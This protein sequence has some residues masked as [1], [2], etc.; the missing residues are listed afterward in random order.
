MLLQCL[1]YLYDSRWLLAITLAIAFLYYFVLKTWSFFD[2][3]N[4]KYV[5]GWPVVGTLYRSV[6]GLE[7]DDSDIKRVYDRY[8]NEKFVGMYDLLG[9]PSYLLRDPELIKQIS[10]TNFDHFVNHRF[11]FDDDVDALLGRSMFG[12]RDEK[13]RRMRSTMSPAFT[14]SKMK[15]MHSLIV[16][17]SQDFIKSLQAAVASGDGVYNAKDLFRRYA[18]DVIYTCA[19]GIK[20]N[21]LTDRDNDFFTT[22]QKIASFDGITNLKFL[23]LITVPGVMKLFNIK[24]IDDKNSNFFRALIKNNMQQRIDKKIVRNDMIDLLIKAREGT[25]VHNDGNERDIDE[26]NSFATVAESNVGKSGDKLIGMY[27]QLYLCLKSDFK[28]FHIPMD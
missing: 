8:P 19:F 27:F 17:Y 1:S 15:L 28:F 2:Q 24:I 4:V 12:M 5:R 26:R 3:R 7:S 22:G 11:Q 21:S 25:L 9:S 6:L 10:I 16:E 14:G 23:G 18:N 13:W 20:V